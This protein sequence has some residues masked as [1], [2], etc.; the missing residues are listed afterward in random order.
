MCWWIDD[1]GLTQIG[2]RSTG[3]ITTPLDVM[4]VD[5]RTGCAVIAADDLTT[6]RPGKT[7]SHPTLDTARVIDTL[8]WHV[9]S[10]E[11]RGEAW[12]Q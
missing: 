8:V 4:S 11:I 3:S 5:G 9:T 1:A 10:G 6:I 7:L 12:L 2:T